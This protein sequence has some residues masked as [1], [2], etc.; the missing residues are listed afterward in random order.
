[1]RYFALEEHRLRHSTDG[2]DEWVA[3]NIRVGGYLSFNRALDAIF[4]RSRNGRI[5][6][7]E[8]K[9]VALVQD[10]KLTYPLLEIYGKKG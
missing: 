3:A 2:V 5:V 9:I 10:G 6:N 8:R 1:M 7:E 4:K